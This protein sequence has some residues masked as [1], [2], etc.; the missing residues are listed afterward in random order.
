MEN[1]EIRRR[2]LWSLVHPDGYK[3]EN[4]RVFAEKT[5]KTDQR[6]RHL[7]N[8]T[9][10]TEPEKPIGDAAAREF[11]KIFNLGRGWMD[12]RHEERWVQYGHINVA[13]DLRESGA[14]KE[15]PAVYPD[16]SPYSVL[17]AKIPIIS[18]VKAG[19]F[20]EAEDVFHPGEADDWAISPVPAGRNCYALR[21]DGDS[22]TSPY[23]GARSYPKGW[24]IIV[25]P[26]QE[27]LP[28]QRG[29]FKLPDSNEVTFKEL[30]SDA[31]QHYLKP[32]NPDY[33]LRVIDK[34]MVAC[35]KVIATYLPE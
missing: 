1:K 31:G 34:N 14:I 24:I 33:K 7:I 15:V 13:G 19:E 25:D 9:P 16:T 12:E 22:M 21:I 5:G 3:K 27:V 4:V 20:C 8:K 11:E 32:L 35:G 17:T 26:D 10:D 29:I 28:G 23:P 30:V 2:N 18:W 6:I